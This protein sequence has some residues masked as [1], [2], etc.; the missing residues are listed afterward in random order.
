MRNIKGRRRKQKTTAGTTP[1]QDTRPHNHSQRHRPSDRRRPGSGSSQQAT[2]VSQQAAALIS[3]QTADVVVEALSNCATGLKA[4]PPL[5]SII[6]QRPVL[7]L[8]HGTCIH[9]V[10]LQ[11]SRTSAPSPRLRSYRVSG[12]DFIFVPQHRSNNGEM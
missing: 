12:S 8:T 9:F 11:S 10:S 4:N 6:S 1:V 5:R 2:L 7:R 3:T